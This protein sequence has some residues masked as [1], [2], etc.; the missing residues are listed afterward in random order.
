[1]QK[2]HKGLTKRF[3]IMCFTSNGNFGLDKNSVLPV[4]SSYIRT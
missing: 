2:K 1:M 4:K 3:S